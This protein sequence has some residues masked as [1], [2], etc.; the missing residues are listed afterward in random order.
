MARR[1]SDRRWSGKMTE[2]S[3]ALDLE[4]DTYNFIEA[5]G[6]SKAIATKAARFSRRCRC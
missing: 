2:T 5:L 1:Q 6:L 4:E 3:D